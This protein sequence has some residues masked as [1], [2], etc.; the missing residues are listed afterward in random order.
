MPAVCFM[1]DD[2]ITSPG[3]AEHV[4]SHHRV[5]SQEAAALILAL[6]TANHDQRLEVVEQLDKQ[7]HSDVGAQPSPS[8]NLNS[9]KGCE[10]EEVQ[11]KVKERLAITHFIIGHLHILMLFHISY[12]TLQCHFID[13]MHSGC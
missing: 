11:L 7:H 9:K 2:P 12:L 3:L 8:P 10:T 4:T 6:Q 13:S 1:C 5:Q